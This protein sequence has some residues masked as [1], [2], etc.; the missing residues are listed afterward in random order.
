MPDEIQRLHQPVKKL[1]KS[2][3][4]QQGHVDH[5]ADVSGHVVDE[6]GCPEPM[7]YVVD[8]EVYAL[9]TVSSLAQYLRSISC[10]RNYEPVATHIDKPKD[11]DIRMRETTPRRAYTTYT[12]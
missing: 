9:Q 7:D 8:E 4:K 10:E 1:L 5:I 11:I 6:R 12:H 2:T 3:W